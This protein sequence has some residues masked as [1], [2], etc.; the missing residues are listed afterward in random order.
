MGKGDHGG[1]LAILEDAKAGALTCKTRIRICIDLL[2]FSLAGRPDDP[3]LLPGGQ[4]IGRQRAL[5]QRLPREASQRSGE[6]GGGPGQ[7]VGGQREDG[8]PQAGRRRGRGGKER[9]REWEVTELY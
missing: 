1:G 2:T 5:L 7:A 3:V 6:V 9:K 4:D 8:R